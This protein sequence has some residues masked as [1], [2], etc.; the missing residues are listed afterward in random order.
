MR[1][2]DGERAPQCGDELRRECFEC[3]ARM[4][5]HFG[6]RFGDNLDGAELERA[7]RGRRARAGIRA[8]HDDRPW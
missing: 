4:S 6:W 7:D 5:E 2:L 1:D 8:D 3:G